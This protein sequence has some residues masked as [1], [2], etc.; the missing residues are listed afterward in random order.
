MLATVQPGGSDPRLGAWTGSWTLIGAQSSLDPSNRL[1]ITPVKDGMHVVMSG[2]T[3]I[4]FT[5]DTKGH[6]S[7]APGNPSFDRIELHRIDKRQ[8]DVK[9]EK[10]GTLVATIHEKLSKDAKEL[11]TTTVSPGKPDQVTVWN[12]SGGAKAAFDLFAGEWTQDFSKSRLRQG[13]TLRIEPD[14]NGGVRFLGDFSYDARLDG[15]RYEVRGSRNDTVVL[16][17]TDPHVIDAIYRRADQITQR[18]KWSVSADGQ[19]MTLSTTATLETGQKLIE[20]LVFK[21][22]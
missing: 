2:E 21:K 3:H 13:L 18:D 5:A 11:T 7:P 14:G 8:A 4:D 22:Q 12:R 15:K 10:G 19:Q 16:Q 17:S 9:E 1:I 6:P 20:N